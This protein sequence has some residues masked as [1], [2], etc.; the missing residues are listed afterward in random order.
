MSA[1]NVVMQFADRKF[2]GKQFDCGNGSGN[3]VRNSVLHA[4][5]FFLVSANFTSAIVAQLFGTGA[6]RDCVRAAWS[7]FYFSCFRA[8]H[9]DCRAI[10]GL[11]DSEAVFERHPFPRAWTYFYTIVP[12]GIFACLSAPLF[13]FYSGRGKTLPVALINIGICLANIIL[14]WVL[15][16]GKFGLPRMG[17]FG[18]GIATSLSAMGGF[19]AILT[20]YLSIDQKVYPT[21]SLAPFP[22]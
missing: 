16:F 14:D 2:L 13:A 5:L 17:I 8:A 1:S 7:G 12:S 20:L 11:S 22:V 4:V 3:A 15:I 6:R 9:C 18:A 10:S 21:R 19:L